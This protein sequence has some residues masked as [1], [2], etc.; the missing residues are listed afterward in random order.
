MKK[1]ILRKVR[2]VIL[3]DELFK[4]VKQEK[5]K[6]NITNSN[7]DIFPMNEKE[8]EKLNSCLVA[9]RSTNKGVY[10]NSKNC[11]IPLDI[12]NSFDDK[13]GRH[14]NAFLRAKNGFEHSKHCEY[15]IRET[16]FDPSESNSIVKFK[17]IANI[18]RDGYKEYDGTFPTSVDYWKVKKELIHNWNLEDYI[19]SNEKYTILKL[20]FLIKMNIKEFL[21][22]NEKAMDRNENKKLI[23]NFDD[24]GY[25][26]KIVLIY[27]QEIINNIKNYEDSEI[28]FIYNNPTFVI[29]ENGKKWMNNSYYVI[30]DT[31]YEIRKEF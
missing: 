12:I 27:K 20:T 29:D 7:N 26:Y 21:K 1:K 22:M 2:G 19:E 13:N 9:H 6:G 8:M 24:I 3:S 25:N 15:V 18:W 30:D 14:I 16:Y 10:C 4:Y 23:L 5:I 17:K 31:W 11:K 28:V